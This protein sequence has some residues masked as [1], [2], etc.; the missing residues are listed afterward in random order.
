MGPGFPCNLQFHPWI[1]WVIFPISSQ[2]C[3][4][5][6]KFFFDKKKKKSKGPTSLASFPFIGRYIFNKNYYRVFVLIV[7]IIIVDWHLNS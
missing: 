1:R 4:V 5:I 7:D 3:Y 2:N 6:N